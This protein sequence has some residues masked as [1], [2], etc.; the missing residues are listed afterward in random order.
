MIKTDHQLRSYIEEIMDDQDY[1]IHRRDD[2]VVVFTYHE[3]VDVLKK[4]LSQKETSKPVKVQGSGEI[5]PQ[6]L[7]YYFNDEKT[8]VTV[9]IGTLDGPRYPIPPA[10][11]Q[12]I[13]VFIKKK[14]SVF[15]KKWSTGLILISNTETELDL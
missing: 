15:I 3:C 4:H 9:V 2:D 5:T 14:H 13:P 7:V 12:W 8:P 1:Y 11:G 10:S 6:T